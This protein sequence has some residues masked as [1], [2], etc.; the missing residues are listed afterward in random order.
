M[1][2]STPSGVE[3]TRFRQDLSGLRCH[4]RFEAVRY[5]TPVIVKHQ[6][7]PG[8][9]RA[10]V[11]YCALVE[12]PS[13]T[14]LEVEANLTANRW[15]DMA[16][17]GSLTWDEVVHAAEAV[18]L[19]AST[20]V[21]EATPDPA[22][23]QLLRADPSTTIRHDPAVLGNV[24]SILCGRTSARQVLTHHR[25]YGDT[26]TYRESAHV[27]RSF[28]DKGA[29]ARH[30]RQL[31]PGAAVR[32]ET[33][34]RSFGDRPLYLS[35]SPRFR[36]L[37]ES[38]L[39]WMM[40]IL[41]EARALETNEFGERVRRL[42]AAKLPDGEAVGFAEAVRLAGAWALWDEGQDPFIREGLSTRSYYEWKKRLATV[43]AVVPSGPEAW[44][45]RVEVVLAS[46]LYRDGD[47]QGDAQGRLL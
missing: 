23:W 38:D 19:W 45:D 17:P 30:D 42:L 36:A 39:A 33:R 32:M 25:S 43:L 6:V 3:T 44:V 47:H 21:D 37:V 20:M 40:D 4:K 9:L 46:D 8:D 11:S 10:G 1:G 31:D 35:E 34:R 41:K 24:H 18:T 2:S 14:Y 13:M 28:Y 12:T 26:L 16:T 5:S 22:H 27:S 7:A 15:G 29:K